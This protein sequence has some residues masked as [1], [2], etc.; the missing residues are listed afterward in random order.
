MP[1]ATPDV[2]SR[3]GI[4]SSPSRTPT[5][6]WRSCPSRTSRTRPRH[7]CRTS[8]ASQDTE[9]V[10]S[11]HL[12]YNSGCSLIPH[13]RCSARCEN[14]DRLN[15]L[16]TFTRATCQKCAALSLSFPRSCCVLNKRCIPPTIGRVDT[17]P[18][19]AGRGWA[20]ES[21]WS[22]ASAQHER[23]WRVASREATEEERIQNRVLGK[24]RKNCV[25]GKQAAAPG[26][27][28]FLGMPESSRCL[29]ESSTRNQI[30]PR[31]LLVTVDCSD[32]NRYGLHEYPPEEALFDWELVAT[33]SPHRNV[34]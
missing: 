11:I 22:T 23:L 18:S 10:Q 21:P 16:Y 34:G 7:R 17:P 24:Q 27:G 20:S 29:T 8:S 13:T 3:K 9:R 5:G 12:L 31:L 14:Y 2:V 28:R 19:G 1:I 25:F 15:V 26:N 4:L 32:L 30:S 6:Y 33:F